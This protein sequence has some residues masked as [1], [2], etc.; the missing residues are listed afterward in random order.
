MRWRAPDEE[1]DQRGCGER[2]CEKD[3]QACNLNREDAMDHSRW[4]KLRVDDDQSGWWV[5]ECSFW[6]RLTQVVPNKGP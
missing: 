6:Y 4:K 5:G 1:V 2:L 3:C